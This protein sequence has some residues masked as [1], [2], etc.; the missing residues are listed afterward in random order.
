VSLSVRRSGSRLALAA[1]LLVL[2]GCAAGRDPAPTAVVTQE[3]V[4]DGVVPLSRAI[5]AV[6]P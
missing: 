2:A 3:P 4:P 1:L 6:D 5:E